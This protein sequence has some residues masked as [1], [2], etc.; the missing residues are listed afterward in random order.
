MSDD[1]SIPML[2]QYKC[3]LLDQAYAGEEYSQ[4]YFLEVLGRTPN[5]DQVTVLASDANFPY[6]PRKPLSATVEVAH[7]FTNLLLTVVY[8]DSENGYSEHDLQARNDESALDQPEI[9]G[10]LADII[11]QLIDAKQA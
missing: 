1:G 3:D 8:L 11:Q 10:A 5:V 6:E 2:L 4:D 9:R 7:G